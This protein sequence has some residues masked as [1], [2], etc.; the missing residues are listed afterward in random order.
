MF[1]IVIFGVSYTIPFGFS[2]FLHVSGISFQ[3]LKLLLWQR[4]TDEGSVPEMRIWSILL[5][6]SDL[7][8]CKIL[9]EVS[10]NISRSVE[11]YFSSLFRIVKQIFKLVFCAAPRVSIVSSEFHVKVLSNSDHMTPTYFLHFAIVLTSWYCQYRQIC[12]DDLRSGIITPWDTRC[13]PTKLSLRS[14][15]RSVFPSF[16]NE[17]SYKCSLLKLYCRYLY[18]RPC[19]INHIWSL[20]QLWLQVNGHAWFHLQRLRWPVRNREGAKNSKWKY[21][22]PAGFEPTPCQSTTRKL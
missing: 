8:W 18:T 16:Y 5:I 14:T 9:V 17:I 1:E 4:T 3:L 7:K 20:K 11:S 19:M 13:F 15:E 6:N 10:F 2:L 12:H 21:M 22:S